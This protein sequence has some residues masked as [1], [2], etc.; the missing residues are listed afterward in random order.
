MRNL[1]ILFI[2]VLSATFAQAEYTSVRLMGLG[3]DFKGIIEDTKTDVLFNPARIVRLDENLIF[4]QFQYK[5]REVNLVGLFPRLTSRVGIGSFLRGSYDR[6][7]NALPEQKEI[8]ASWSRI[9]IYESS[10]YED[11]YNRYHLVDLFGGYELSS[12]ASVGF[13]YTYEPSFTSHTFNTEYARCS[14]SIVRVDTTQEEGYRNRLDE[15][16]KGIHRFRFGFLLEDQTENWEFFGEYRITHRDYTHSS[17]KENH[18]S[19]MYVY[20]DTTYYDTIF[21]YYYHLSRREEVRRQKES[22]DKQTDSKVLELTGRYRGK[23]SNTKFNILALFG[24]ATEQLPEDR[25]DSIT[26][27]ESYFSLRVRDGDTT[28]S[29]EETDWNYEQETRVSGDAETVFGKIG[30]GMERWI[31]DERLLL[32][33][34]AVLRLNR[35]TGQK[36]ERAQF[37]VDNEMDTAY[38]NLLSFKELEAKLAIPIGMEYLVHPTTTLRFGVA[39]SG[40]YREEEVD[41]VTLYNESIKV[42][43]SFGVSF[44]P[45]PNFSF[46]IYTLEP[47]SINSWTM[48]ATFKF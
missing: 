42:L 16:D 35:R 47:T 3:S 13:S 45:I 26:Y 38:T 1:S 22:R 37:S 44:N 25:R 14:W 11:H 23:L 41:G 39:V 43:R 30:V 21:H 7:S 4:S 27:D 5:Q 12:R 33:G 46:D 40:Y 2:I 29:Q 8:D 6:G 28:I 32:L 34:G 24:L 36:E 9:Y 10:R 19:D 20:S 18:L 15:E 31:L 48:E 17:Q